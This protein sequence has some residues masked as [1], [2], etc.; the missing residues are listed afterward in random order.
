MSDEIYK[1]NGHMAGDA[2]PDR[3]R[4][5]RSTDV[6]LGISDVLHRHITRHVAEQRP[7]SQRRL[8]FEN[9]RPR[10]YREMAAESIGV[11]LFGRM[12]LCSFS[13]R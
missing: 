8:N 5:L 11:F 2:D 12:M 13:A 10:W 6:E 3:L 1:T 4:R 7:V 9:T